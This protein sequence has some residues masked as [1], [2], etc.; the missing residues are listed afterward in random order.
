[1]QLFYSAG[2]V[3]IP[4]TG[5]ALEEPGMDN[6]AWF[7]PTCL[8]CCFGRTVATF[9]FNQIGSLLIACF[10]RFVVVNLKQLILNLSE[11]R[12]F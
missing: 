5:T 2:L 9:L 10:G 1:M 8:L 11:V 7:E 4:R 6:M 12:L 3:K